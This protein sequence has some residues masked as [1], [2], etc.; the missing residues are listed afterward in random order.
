MGTVFGTIISEEHQVN[1]HTRFRLIH[2][3]IQFKR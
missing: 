2:K 1:R 3:D